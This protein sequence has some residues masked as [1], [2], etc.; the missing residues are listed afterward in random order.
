MSSALIAASTAVIDA[1][2]VSDVVMSSAVVVAPAVFDTSVKLV[3]FA[4]AITKS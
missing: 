1:Y 3:F 4:I 2:A